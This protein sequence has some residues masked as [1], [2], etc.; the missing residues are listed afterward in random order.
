LPEDGINREHAI[1]HIFNRKFWWLHLSVAWVCGNTGSLEASGLSLV[2]KFLLGRLMSWLGSY[3]EMGI[4]QSKQIGYSHI[5]LQ[6]VCCPSFSPPLL[7]CI[8]SHT[9]YVREQLEAVMHL[10]HLCSRTAR[11]EQPGFKSLCTC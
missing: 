8:C 5:L 2:S 1:L 6:R 4:C 7:K 9:G 3:F 10:F 11:C